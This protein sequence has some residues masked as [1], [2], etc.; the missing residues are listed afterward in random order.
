MTDR[1][2]SRAKSARPSGSVSSDGVSFGLAR[3]VRE[4]AADL[5]R[6][7]AKRRIVESDIHDICQEVYLRLLRFERTEIIQNPHAYL[8]RVAANVAHDFNL[9]KRQWTALES[10]Q[11]DELLGTPDSALMSDEAH[12]SRIL[13]AVLA[14]LPPLPRAALALLAQEDLTYEEIAARLGVSR[15]VVKRAVARGYALARE[16]LAERKDP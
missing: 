4:Y 5:E 6:F 10:E 15:R 9:R 14:Q 16:S 3:W 8:F 7:L 2:I 1:P 11:L 13:A 12:R